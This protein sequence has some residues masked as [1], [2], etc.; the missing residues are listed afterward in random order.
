MLQTFRGKVCKGEGLQYNTD[1][2]QRLA[3][4]VFLVPYFF[5]QVTY[6][7]SAYT[8][9]GSPFDSEGVGAGT[10]LK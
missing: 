2:G 8:I 1:T 6:L 10:L 7:H 3:L 5:P 4:H 9:G